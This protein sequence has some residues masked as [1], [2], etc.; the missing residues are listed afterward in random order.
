MTP[1][2]EAVDFFKKVNPHMKDDPYFQIPENSITIQ[3]F[4]A[5]HESGKESGEEDLWKRINEWK[6]TL[7]FCM[8]WDFLLIENGDREFEACHCGPFPLKFRREI[9]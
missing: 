8:E 4:L 2:E 7:H 6:P 9:K 3:A 5:G 1:Q